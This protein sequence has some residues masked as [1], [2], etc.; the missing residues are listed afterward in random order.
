[1]KNDHSVIIEFRTL[2]AN[3]PDHA[4]DRARELLIQLVT[5]F[6]VDEYTLDSVETDDDDPPDRFDPD[7]RPRYNV[8]FSRDF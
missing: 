8:T 6:D 7:Y 4:C 3:D 2:D 1:M 5:R